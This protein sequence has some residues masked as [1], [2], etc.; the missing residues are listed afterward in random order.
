MPRS[1][2]LVL[3][4]ASLAQLIQASGAT[5]DAL[6]VAGRLMGASAPHASG[7]S[8]QGC[9]GGRPMPLQLQHQ[10]TGAR[11]NAHVPGCSC[12]G[13]SGGQQMRQQLTGSRLPMGLMMTPMLASV[14]TRA[15]LVHLHHQ[16]QQ[17]QAV[18]SMACSA[19]LGRAPPSVITIEYDP[20]DLEAFIRV[21]DA[22]EEAFPTVVVQGNEE[23]EGRPGSFEILIDDGVSIFSRL[24]AGATSA[25]P[26]ADDV[27]SRI[28]SRSKLSTAGDRTNQPFCQ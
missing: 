17:P 25:L 27:I 9:A 14:A 23:R 15:G 24:S 6:P 28:A 1:V 19:G 10:M 12:Q 5:A 7:C 11:A 21:A 20:Q 18:R 2:Q 8:C 26:G 13:C 16:H 22:V 3:R 4:A